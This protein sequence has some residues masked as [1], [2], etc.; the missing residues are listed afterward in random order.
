MI[1]YLNEFKKFLGASGCRLLQYPVL[2]V[3]YS[4]QFFVS[5]WQMSL[6]DIGP[7]INEYTELRKSL[8]D[9]V[10]SRPSPSLSSAEYKFE[11]FN[12]VLAERVNIALPI[13]SRSNLEAYEASRTRLQREKPEWFKNSS[14]CSLWI[15]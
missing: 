15:F 5:F 9:Y 10:Q 1:Y 14:T 8:S 6:A 3:N 2:T 4:V 11:A 7:P 12:R 13:E